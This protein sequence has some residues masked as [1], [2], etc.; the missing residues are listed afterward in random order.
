MVLVVVELSATGGGGFTGI[1]DSEVTIIEGGA[2][3]E[4]GY[5]HQP[6][7][8]IIQMREQVLQIQFPQPMQVKSCFNR[9]CWWYVG[10]NSN[11]DIHRLKWWWWIY[12]W[13]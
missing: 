13:N 10:E 5:H 6:D 1:F 12:C 11:G 8:I 7:Q 4:L 3:N 2:Y 9:R